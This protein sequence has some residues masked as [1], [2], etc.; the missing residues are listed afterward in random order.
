MPSLVKRY[1]QDP[2][3]DTF[4]LFSGYRIGEVVATQ[5]DPMQGIDAVFDRLARKTA[6]PEAVRL[7]R[8]EVYLPP[9]G[10]VLGKVDRARF[11]LERRRCSNSCRGAAPATFRATR[12]PRSRRYVSTKQRS[13]RRALSSV[14]TSRPIRRAATPG[15]RR[16]A[17]RCEPW[18]SA[19]AASAFREVAERFR[20]DPV[21]RMLG[22]AYAARAF[23]IIRRLVRRRWRGLAAARGVGRRLRPAASSSPA[24]R[25]RTTG[26]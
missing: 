9:S 17:S 26:A 10:P 3:S 7:S 23:E 4:T 18:R 1:A 11:M 16:F 21:A 13:R 19:T 25:A 5:G 12:W 2:S 22:R 20:A 24:A 8:A 14:S 6:Q 15:W